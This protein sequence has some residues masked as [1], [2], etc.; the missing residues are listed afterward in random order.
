[1]YIAY[2]FP[3]FLDHPGNFRTQAFL[4]VQLNPGTIHSF[5]GSTSSTSPRHL[6]ATSESLK[7]LSYRSCPAWAAAGGGGGGAEPSLGPL[8]EA[9]TVFEGSDGDTAPSPP[10]RQQ[11]R[12][13]DAG[14]QAKHWGLWHEGGDVDGGGD[15]GGGGGAHAPRGESPGP[16]VEQHE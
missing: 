9:E 10:P 1:M 3:S 5:G 13:A 8:G 4:D 16:E 11:Q 12:H 14:S 2:T 6:D 15:G 7:Q